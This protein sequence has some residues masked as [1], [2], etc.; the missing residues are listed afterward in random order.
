MRKGEYNLDIKIISAH[1]FSILIRKEIEY[2]NALLLGRIAMLVMDSAIN[3]YIERG[4]E[5]ACLNS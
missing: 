5:L 2:R 3:T 1:V 4:E